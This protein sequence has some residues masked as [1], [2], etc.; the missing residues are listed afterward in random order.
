MRNNQLPT[1]APYRSALYSD[2]G[3]AVL[4]L[5][6]ERLTGEEYKDAVKS[7]I[8]EPLGMNSSSS[9]APNGTDIDAVER[10]GLGSWGTDFPVVAG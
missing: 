4:T 5:V 7:L 8:F 6:L 2:A 10:I 9:V 1:I 3:Y